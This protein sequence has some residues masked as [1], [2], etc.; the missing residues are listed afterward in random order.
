MCNSL[1]LLNTNL[2]NSNPPENKEVPFGNSDKSFF[3]NFSNNLSVK[4]TLV[5]VS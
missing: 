3:F 2:K 1:L 5:L 4:V